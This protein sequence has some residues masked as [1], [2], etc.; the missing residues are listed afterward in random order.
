MMYYS[1]QGITPA[2]DGWGTTLRQV[3]KTT[4]QDAEDLF[5]QTVS[6]WTDNGAAGNGVDWPTHAAPPEAQYG[7]YLQLNYTAVGEDALG[8]MVDSIATSGGIRPRASQID[9]WWYPTTP[10]HQF[11][12]GTDWV[13]PAEYYPNGMAGLSERLATPVMMYMPAVCASNLTTK[14]DALFNWSDTADQGWKLPVAD[15]MELFFE[16]LFDYGIKT[17]TPAKGSTG[18]SGS[19]LPTADPWPKT[20]APPMVKEGWRGTHMAGYETDFFSDLQ[21]GN[22]ESRTVVGKGEMLLKGIN[23]A[24]QARNLTVQICGG[25]V[26][27]FLE[28]LTL[29]TI[30]NARA[31][32]DYDGDATGKGKHTVNSFENL[33]APDNAWPFWGT[34]MG[35]S[36]DNFW[37]SDKNVYT[38]SSTIMYGGSQVGHDA[39]VSYILQSEHMAIRIPLGVLR[40]CHSVHQPLP[41]P[42]CAVC[43]C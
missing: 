41:C 34:R 3:H 37:T 22:P 17:A 24:A 29:P 33:P 9:C 21:S 7:E 42:R 13:L 14:W 19:P 40:C 1:G 11:Y 5:L 2:V 32:N 10:Q 20:W 27:D 25:T 23:K 18:A 12:C 16:M 38:N 31:T 4:K 26:P 35:M 30:T 39:E 6:Y 36:K 43:A 8:A 28:S 15:E